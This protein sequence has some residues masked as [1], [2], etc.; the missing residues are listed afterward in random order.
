MRLYR[1][2]ILLTLIAAVVAPGPAGTAEVGVTGV[3]LG[4]HGAT[5]RFVLD[6]TGRVD[7]RLF[8][9]PDPYRVVI[10]MPALEWRPAKPPGGT[11]ALIQGLRYG[12]FR[13]DVFRVVLDVG[14]PV[15]VRRLFFL[16]PADGQG[17]RFVLD[18]E[19]ASREAFLA[20]KRGSLTV[21]ALAPPALPE[22]SSAERDKPVVVLDPGHGG[23]DPG[24]ISPGGTYEKDITLAVALEVRRQIEAM[25][26]FR[27]VMTRERD[28]FVS[29]ARRVETAKAARADIFI[30]LHA[31][32]IKDKGVRGGSVYTLSEK[33]SDALAEELAQHANASD[34]IAGVD[35]S[36][37]SPEVAN[38]L[39][40]LAR[41]K[42]LN[43]S[44]DAA[45]VVLAGLAE[46][47]SLL[48][49]SRRH[50]GFAV[51]KG[52]EVPSILVELGFL[53]NRQD[54]RMLGQ[55]AHQRRLA[56]AVARAVDGWF[57]RNRR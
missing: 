35:F 33:A 23:V 45:D 44:A 48:K 11:T 28:V 57:G 43:D 14:R 16:P 51:L 8:T 19:P 56:Q 27:V 7:F 38:I 15:S 6:L 5:T 17:P 32:A 21:A 52:P 47:T 55:P 22:P 26:K 54:E 42:A 39:I 46:A 31:D 20:E 2:L 4:E 36:D 9:L 29:L 40:D 1:A 13:P 37:K 41:R 24:A 53:S 49:T 3:R 34:V 25:G 12:L 18:L 30:S 50:A 10:D